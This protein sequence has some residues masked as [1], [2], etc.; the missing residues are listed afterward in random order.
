MQYPSLKLGIE[1]GNA[2]VF[3][4]AIKT[5][6]VTYKRAVK[7]QKNDANRVMA[8]CKQLRRDTDMD[9]SIWQ[10]Y[11]ARNVTR[12]MISGFTQMM[13]M[14]RSESETAYQWLADKDPKHWSRV[15]FKGT[16]LCDMLCNSMCESYN[17]T[18]LKASDKPV[19]TLM[20][21]IMNHLMKMLVRK[22]AEMEK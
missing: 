7:C 21:M 18:I 12:E 4:K 14:M 11:H 6:T 9:A 15:F 16:T 3:R 2:D 10:F 1:F 5:H 13:E 20:E 8:V 22:R 17:A 19:I